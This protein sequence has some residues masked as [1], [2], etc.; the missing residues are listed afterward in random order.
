MARSYA[1]PV[2]AGKG[3]TT[4]ERILDAALELFVER[5][6]RGTTIS[7]VERRVG[8]AA[9]TGS[10]YRHFRSK[11]ELLRA[12]VE[13]EAE[14]CMTESRDERAALPVLD[15]PDEQLV[16]AAHQ[17]LGDIRRFE[18]LLRLVLAEGDRVPEVRTAVAAALQDAH[19]LGPWMDDPEFLVGV[20]ALAGFHLFGL[21]QGGP[22]DG[23][24][25]DEFIRTLVSLISH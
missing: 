12:A 14:R 24:S 9:G 19:A 22:L 6:F 18:R 23:V 11:E 7:D 4:R 17:R 1:A 15:D 25:E 2:S 8:L 5:G 21:L 16:A 10:F 20:A 13:R 3:P